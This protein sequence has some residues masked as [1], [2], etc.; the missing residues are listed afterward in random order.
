LSAAS[1]RSL[2]GCEFVAQNK[3]LWL[4]VVDCPLV[5]TD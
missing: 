2:Y 4:V 5:P 1:S 3:L